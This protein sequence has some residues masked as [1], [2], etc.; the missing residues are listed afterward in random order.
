MGYVPGPGSK[1]VKPTCIIFNW[2]N[3]E[4]DVIEV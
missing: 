3:M 4:A 1:Q 2:D